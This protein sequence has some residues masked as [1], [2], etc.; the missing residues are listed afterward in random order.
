M[1]SV[2]G[3]GLYTLLYSDSFIGSSEH[4]EASSLS[5]S[6][7]DYM[8]LSGVITPTGLRR[9]FTRINGI[10]VNRLMFTPWLDSPGSWVYEWG[11]DVGSSMKLSSDHSHLL[12]FIWPSSYRRI[13]IFPKQNF[14]IY[15]KTSVRWDSNGL[16][17]PVNILT[18]PLV[19]LTDTA[20]GFRLQYQRIFQGSLLQSLHINHRLPGVKTAHPNLGGILNAKFTYGYDLN[21]NVSFP[22]RESFCI[23]HNV[24]CYYVF[25]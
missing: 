25:T 2:S 12:R 21:M 3:S 24:M 5:S 4:Q 16:K 14:V 6:K 7:S 17:Q 11:S 18:A 15:D 23:I 20:S 10:K 13:S 8:G 19:Q 1:V 22:E 9:Q